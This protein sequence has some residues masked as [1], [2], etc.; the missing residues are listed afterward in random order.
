MA[1]GVKIRGAKH[2]SKRQEKEL[3]QRAVDLAEDPEILRPR[4]IG[5]CRR[6]H[7][8]KSFKRISSLRPIMGD[9]EKLNKAA[10]RGS[11]SLFKAYAGTVSLAAAGK[12]PYLATAK[13]PSGDISFAVRG[14]VKH[15]KLIGVQYY[16][17]PDMRLLA[18][19]DTSKKRKLRMYSMGDE[20]LC[21]DRPGFPDEY[22]D[23]RA[24]SSTYDL[25]EEGSCGHE[26]SRGHLVLS[27]DGGRRTVR[28][29]RSCAGDRNL[30]HHF[31]SRMTAPDPLREID[32]HVVHSYHD[33]ESPELQDFL[34]DE[35]LRE[36][37][38][39]GSLND[40]KL[41]DEVV[42]RRSQEMRSSGAG[43]LMIGDRNY[44]RDLESFLK[45]LRGSDDEKQVLRNFLEKDFVTVLVKGDRSSE[46]INALWEEHHDA[47]I[48]AASSPE[49]LE[50]MGDVSGKNPGKAVSEAIM[51]QQAKGILADIPVF[52]EL[53]EVGGYADR[54]A[55]AFKTGGPPAVRKYIESETRGYRNRAVGLAF[56]RATGEQF[57][58]WQYNKEELDFSE[59]L[60]QFAKAMM[61]AKG[62][63]YADSLANMIVASGSGESPPQ[64]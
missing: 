40:R 55:R 22:I 16:D 17:D 56:L 42:K 50:E 49:V 52:S 64:S 63:A 26:L 41:I 14:K 35:D 36:A 15:D 53:G 8:D 29:C 54:L 24:A 4:C 11:D 33:M 20:V 60:E 62:E 1:R 9:A 43:V 30:L 32:V 57:N 44:G 39:R 48:I 27:M 2:T 37:Y 5:S 61:E 59:Y 34:V 58:T 10:G 6:C 47:L 25:D 45:D 13:M 3:M 28:V 38:V 51:R 23:E 12:I 19:T 21:C 7:F 18:Y 31:I 46:A